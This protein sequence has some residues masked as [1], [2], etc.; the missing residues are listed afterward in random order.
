[1]GLKTSILG[2]KRRHPPAYVRLKCP[3][4]FPHHHLP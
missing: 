3:L 1:V 2:I 4:L